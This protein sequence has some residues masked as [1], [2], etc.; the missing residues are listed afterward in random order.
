MERTESEEVGKKLAQQASVLCDQLEALAPDE[1]AALALYSRAATVSLWA[2]MACVD[3][4]LLDKIID[5]GFYLMIA[6]GRNP[7]RLFPPARTLLETMTFMAW[8]HLERFAYRL[9]VFDLE[10]ANRYASDAL[11]LGEGQEVPQPTTTRAETIIA[12]AAE[13]RYQLGGSAALLDQAITR[14]EHAISLQPDANAMASLASCLRQRAEVAGGEAALRDLQEAGG[15][16]AGLVNLQSGMPQIPVSPLLRAQWLAELALVHCTASQL[17]ESAAE[18]EIA[19]KL[20]QEALEEWPG[21]GAARLATA[22]VVG[23]KHS[24]IRV[25]PLGLGGRPNNTW[26]SLQAAET[27]AGLAAASGSATDA[28][29]S[30]R[31]AWRILQQA[32]DK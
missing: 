13:R 11:T 18:L 24:S 7:E 26:I 14:L 15:L 4:R 20:C 8:C 3:V 9:D 25:R 22:I 2:A 30:S 29:W 19:K 28:V 5:I 10:E 16:L 27:L 17:F 1:G 6:A 23:R 31:I 32:I 21:S 12:C